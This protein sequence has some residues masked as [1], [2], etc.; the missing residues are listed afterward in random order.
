MMSHTY[1]HI[2]TA[3]SRSGA[4]KAPAIKAEPPPCLVQLLGRRTAQSHKLRSAFPCGSGACSLALQGS[5]VEDISRRLEH[6][7]QWQVPRVPYDL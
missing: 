2:I 7:S 6:L 3:A 1:Y 5:V 4:K